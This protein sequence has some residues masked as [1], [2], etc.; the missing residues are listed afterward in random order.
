[1]PIL[2]RI[3]NRHG[4][5]RVFAG[6]RDLESPGIISPSSEVDSHAW[7]DPSQPCLRL[8]PGSV[9]GGQGGAGGSFEAECAETLLSEE[10]WSFVKRL[11]QG[12]SL[13]ITSDHGYAAP[14]LFHDAQGSHKEFLKETF[15]GQRFVKG[16]GETG[17]FVPPVALELQTA[18][19]AHRFSIG[20]W[21]WKSGGGYP[22]VAHGGLSLLE[23]FVPW[24]EISGVRAD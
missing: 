11:A 18:H 13:V 4:H 2:G 1:M 15:K 3:R 22:T 8:H 14:G 9:G 10:F 12:R 23:V 20:R 24:V 6:R 17:A 19:G 5:Q 16:N 7:P 21:K